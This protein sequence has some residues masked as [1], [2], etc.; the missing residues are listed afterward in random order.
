MRTSTFF[1]KTPKL[2]IAWA[3][4]KIEHTQIATKVL[5][6]WRFIFASLA[7]ITT[8]TSDKVCCHLSRSH[9]G[10]A[11]LSGNL[12]AIFHRFHCSPWCIQLGNAKLGKCAHLCKLTQHR[13][14]PVGNPKQSIRTQRIPSPLPKHFHA[15]SHSRQCWRQVTHLPGTSRTCRY[16]PCS[17]L[18]HSP[19][20][21]LLCTSCLPSGSLQS[22][23]S[24]PCLLFKAKAK[25]KRLDAQK[26]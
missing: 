14:F 3:G 5:I 9:R 15:S 19:L 13:S 7:K 20:L 22:P 25:A 17:L 10:L 4:E 26:I 2:P 18:P 6:H 1:T 16:R 24:P 23:Q 12:P 21:L 8:G 11:M